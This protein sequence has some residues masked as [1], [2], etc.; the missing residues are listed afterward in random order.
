MKHTRALFASHSA[1]SDITPTQYAGAL[2]WLQACGLVTEEGRVA[3]PPGPRS[4]MEAALRDALWLPDADLLVPGLVELPEDALRAS[5][6]LGLEPE[7]A[8]AAVRHAWGKVDTETRSRVGSAGEQALVELLRAATDVPVHHVAAI[9]DGYGYDI[10]VGD[11]HIE[12]KSTTRR[13]RLT[14]YLSRNEYE[15]MRRDPAW[16]LTLVRLDRELRP[17]SVATVDNGW[18]ETAVPTDRSERGRWEAARFDV[19]GEAIRSGLPSVGP[20]LRV[21][22]HGLLSDATESLPL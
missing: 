6:V 9:S 2:D 1:Y 3:G 17:V 8:L 19:P 18:I 21:Q 4:V 11:V 10:A 22:G 5:Q 14:I 13:G 16:V 12:V 20:L 7:D 15:T